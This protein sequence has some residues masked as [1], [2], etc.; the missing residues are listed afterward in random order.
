MTNATNKNF[1][2]TKQEKDPLLSQ[3]GNTPLVQLDLPTEATVY[4]KLEF[5]NPGGSIKDRAA[6]YMVQDAEERGLLKPG[7]TIVEGSSG[8]Q[9]IALA[10]IGAVKGYRVIIVVPKHTS[11]EKKAALRAYGAELHVAPDASSHDDPDSYSKRAQRLAEEIP[12]AFMPNQY[13]NI[14]NAE[15]HYRSTGPE[16][17]EQTDGTIT[18]FFCGMGSCGTISGTSKFLKEQNT[19]IHITGADSAHSLL[20]AKTPRAYAVEGIGV[21]V[22]S[23]VLQRQL[24][25]T[26]VPIYDEQAFQTARDYARKGYLVGPSSGAVLHALTTQ[27]H[28]LKRG[29]TAVCILADSGRA[30]LSKLFSVQMSEADLEAYRE[31]NT[32]E[33]QPAR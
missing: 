21:D 19:N 25:D 7:G 15:A 22:I 27:L 10:M 31:E 23:D 33:Q 5:L 12:G 26:I 4:A 18:H 20:S 24:V 2:A 32:S 9:G 17:W 8:N 6:L 30:Y 28:L 29:D 14:K 3:I 11:S 13:Y 1:T 16:I